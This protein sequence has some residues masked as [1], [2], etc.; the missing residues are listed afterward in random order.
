VTFFKLIHVLRRQFKSHFEV[1]TFLCDVFFKIDSR[2][3]T[4]FEI[5]PR[6]VTPIQ[7]SVFVW[8]VDSRYATSAQK[9]F[10]VL[11]RLSFLCDVNLKSFLISMWRHSSLRMRRHFEVVPHYATSV[12]KSFLVV[13]YYVKSWSL[14]CD[15]NPKVIIWM[16]YAI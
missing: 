1:T 9:S 2:Y 8:K 14:L 3:V 15:V 11:R 12:Q 4:Y 7:K 10:L 13:W 5:F 6:C 16:V